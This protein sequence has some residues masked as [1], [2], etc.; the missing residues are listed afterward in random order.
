M[1]AEPV[2]AVRA[3]CRRQPPVTACACVSCVVRVT[4]R[5]PSSGAWMGLSYGPDWITGG[6]EGLQSVGSV[7][8]P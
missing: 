7:A 8:A 1:G 4:W 6:Y 5:P 2:A 3:H